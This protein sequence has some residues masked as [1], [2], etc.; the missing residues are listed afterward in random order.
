MRCAIGGSERLDPR[1]TIANQKSLVI[2][3]GFLYE[4]LVRFAASGA[5]SG[6][7]WWILGTVRAPCDAIDRVV[8][9]T[10]H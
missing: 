3:K 1:A 7:E 8:I 9:E 2:P 4:L 5:T 10:K 6:A